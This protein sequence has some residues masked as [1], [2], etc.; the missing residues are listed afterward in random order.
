M[1]N[2]LND[3]ESNGGFWL[4]NIQRPFVQR[5]DQIERL[6]DSIM[7]EYPISTLLVWR[8][9]SP[10]RRRKFIDNYK[11]SLK[12]TDFYVPEDNKVKL[13]VLDGQQRLQSLFIG[14][15]GSYEKRELFFDVLSGDIVP[16][17]DIESI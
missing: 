15:K 5:E 6:F 9:K 11:Y 2:Y 4:P 1:V 17:E 16:P 14:L 10:I 13:L 12:L 3:E 8:T 7:R